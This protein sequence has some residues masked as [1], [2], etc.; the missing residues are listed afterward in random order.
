MGRTVDGSG[1]DVSRKY[2]FSRVLLVPWTADLTQKS[3]SPPKLSDIALSLDCAINSL[4]FLSRSNTFAFP[5]AD[6]LAI[7]GKGALATGDSS[8]V[9]PLFLREWFSNKASKSGMTTVDQSVVH[10][11]PYWFRTPMYSLR[12]AAACSLRS[13]PARSNILVTNSLKTKQEGRFNGRRQSSRNELK[14]W[15]PTHWLLRFSRFLRSKTKLRVNPRQV[16]ER[17]C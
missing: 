15:R 16:D 6:F 3:S 9:N 17:T 12:M 2:L 14:A 7:F 8:S 13:L 11:A 10:S 4:D 1:A 5:T